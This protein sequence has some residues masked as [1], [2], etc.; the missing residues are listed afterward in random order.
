MV[1]LQN[2]SKL[3]YLYKVI[4]NFI[5]C[6]ICKRSLQVIYIVHCVTYSMV[7]SGKFQ[8]GLRVIGAIIDCFYKQIFT[9]KSI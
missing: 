5:L 9:E 1:E 7:I 6:Y 2:D 3:I 8:C 4:I